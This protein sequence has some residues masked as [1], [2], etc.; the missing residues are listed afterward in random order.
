M[1]AA[2]ALPTLSARERRSFCRRATAAVFRDVVRN[3]CAWQQ[4]S[5]PRIGAVSAGAGRSSAHWKAFDQRLAELG[6]VDGKN[7]VIE[8]RNAE[9]KPERFR[10]SWRSLSD[11]G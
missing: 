9:G 4:A 10:E 5:L 7:I 1:T 3:Y 2:G 11:P 6:Y 8:F